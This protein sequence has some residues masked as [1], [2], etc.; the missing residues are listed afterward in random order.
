MSAAAAEET[1]ETAQAAPSPAGIAECLTAAADGSGSAT[2]VDDAQAAAWL[3][4]MAVVELLPALL[5][6]RLQQVAGL[7]HFEYLVLVRLIEAPEGLLRMTD[8]ADATNASL[9]RLSHVVARMEARGL[10][11]RRPCPG[12]RRATNAVVTDAGRDRLA[13]ARPGYTAAVREHFAD[14]LDPAALAAVDSASAAML[15]V[16][17]PA[18]RLRVRFQEPGAVPGCLSG[19]DGD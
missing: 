10:I 3:R 18:N 14:L 13:L 6:A 2:G 9:P 8:L 7:T 11:E 12:D 5:D 19:A 1:A 4:F 17:D 15:A 16:L